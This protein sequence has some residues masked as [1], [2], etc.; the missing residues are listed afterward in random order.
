MIA[1][2]NNRKIKRRHCIVS[3]YHTCSIVSLFFVFY[4]YFQ[5]NSLS[6]PSV[7]PPC[8]CSCDGYQRSANSNYIQEHRENGNNNERK[9]YYESNIKCEDSNSKINIKTTRYG[10]STTHI[11]IISKN[12]SFSENP[13]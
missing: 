13:M 10:D 1:T 9:E 12:L 5:L 11:H 8:E 2:T 7:C 4:L 3:F 6:N